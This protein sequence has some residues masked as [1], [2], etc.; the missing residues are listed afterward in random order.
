[1]SKMSFFILFFQFQKKKAS[2]IVLVLLLLFC[3]FSFNRSSSLSDALNSYSPSKDS[4]W[5]LYDAEELISTHENGDEVTA[6]SD[7]SNYV[8]ADHNLK[9]PSDRTSTQQMFFTENGVAGLPS[10]RVHG[11]HLC[12][13]SAVSPPSSGSL[14]VI[15]SFRLTGFQDHISDEEDHVWAHFIGQGG[16]VNNKW[17]IRQGH[18]NNNIGL[19]VGS[20]PETWT[21]RVDIEWNEDFVGV[22]RFDKDT[23]EV[24]NTIHNFW[25]KSLK[26]TETHDYNND[27]PTGNAKIC[28]GWAATTQPNERM[29]GYIRQIAVYD[30]YLDNTTVNHIRRLFFEQVPV[31]ANDNLIPYSGS[32]NLQRDYIF[33]NHIVVSS[34]LTLQGKPSS[35]TQE[36]TTL[37]Q[38]ASKRLFEVTNGATLTLKQVKIKGGSGTIAKQNLITNAIAFYDF[39]VSMKDTVGKVGDMR[40]IRGSASIGDG[41]ADGHGLRIHSPHD[42]VRTKFLASVKLPFT[43]TIFACITLHNLNE[44]GGAAISIVKGGNE[45]DAL[46]YAERETKKWMVGSNSFR[47]TEDVA[48]SEETVADV[49]VCIAATYAIWKSTNRGVIQMYRNGV[50]YGIP[51]R[52]NKDDAWLVKNEFP[53]GEW[54]IVIGDLVP[55]AGTSISNNLNATVHQVG[56]WDR[57]LTDYEIAILIGTYTSPGG[58]QITSGTL[59][60]IN[61]ILTQYGWKGMEDGRHIFEK[62]AG[63]TVIIQNSILSYGFGET[64][65]GKFYDGQR[66][67]AGMYIYSYLSASDTWEVAELATVIDHYCF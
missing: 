38:K 65:W 29:Y 7:L 57:P 63:Q 55:Q 27:M 50:K 67:C 15:M 53:P 25:D 8:W 64:K 24:H 9:K 14:T 46:V 19:G 44:A 20:S 13:N 47:N 62:A 33:Y 28:V 16:G 48:P 6:M 58:I 5:A 2:S 23:Q 61:S 40:F 21:D 36:L 60:V 49:K 41:G 3:K 4:I 17:Q 42:K 10:I 26:N 11:S 30:S 43:K 22:F 39:T 31:G 32:F 51:Y 1:M 54:G 34:S 56:V 18:S 12:T 45:F 52:K 37:H 66:G 35:T 59:H